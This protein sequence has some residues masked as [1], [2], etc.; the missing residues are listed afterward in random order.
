MSCFMGYLRQ[1]FHAAL[2]DLTVTLGKSFFGLEPGF[3]HHFGDGDF[4]EMG[5]VSG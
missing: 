3:F 1:V 5:Q 4:A 2:R